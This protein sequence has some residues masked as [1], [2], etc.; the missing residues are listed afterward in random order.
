M[1]ICRRRH[2]VCRESRHETGGRYQRE[3]Q[4]RNEGERPG[5]DAV[6]VGGGQHPEAASRVRCGA[7]HHPDE[8]GHHAGRLPGPDRRERALHQGDRGGAPQGRRRRGRPQHEGRPRRAAGGAGDRRDAAPGGPPG[9]PGLVGQPQAGGDAPRGAHRDLLASARAP[10]PQPHAGSG[11]RLAPGE[12]RHAAQEDRDRGPRRRDRRGGGDPPDGVGR[13]GLAVHP[14]GAD[15]SR[16]RPGG[17]RDRNA[18]GRRP[19]PRCARLPPRS[20]HLVRGRGRA[21]LP[22]T[23]GGGMPASDRRLTRRKRGTASHW[24]GWSGASTGG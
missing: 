1:E 16:G 19:R 11:D 7:R 2:P 18:A 17:P 6:H 14:R 13:Q 8:G 4:N 22:E 9:R 5:A 3:N 23:P 12:P 20:G 15:A 10:A 21:L 24:R